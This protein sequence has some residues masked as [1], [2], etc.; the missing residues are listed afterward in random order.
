MLFLGGSS[1][2]QGVMCRILFLLQWLREHMLRQSLSLSLGPRGTRMDRVPQ[3]T[4]VG[5]ER[6]QE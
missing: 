4:L 5:R 2:I 3:P 1:K 6:E